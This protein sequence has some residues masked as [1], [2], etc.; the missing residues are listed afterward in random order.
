VAKGGV[1][2][3]LGLL[4]GWYW[5]PLPS[6]TYWRSGNEWNGLLVAT[7]DI[8]K[9]REFMVWQNDHASSNE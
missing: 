5:L 3:A 8:L 1:A 4:G 7:V 2:V 6:T 9:R